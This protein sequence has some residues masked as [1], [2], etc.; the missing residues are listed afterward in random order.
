MKKSAVVASI[1]V[2]LAACG[3]ANAQMC[4]LGKYQ[5][6]PDWRTWDYEVDDHGWANM[7]LV[8]IPWTGD[9]ATMSGTYV[10]EKNPTFQVDPD[11]SGVSNPTTVYGA[12][13]WNHHDTTD[14]GVYGPV[15]FYDAGVATSDQKYL[16]ELDLVKS[17]WECWYDADR[18]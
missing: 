7:L 12:D 13:F 15:E 11:A 6:E 2:M 10:I 1:L 4:Q 14:Q 9:A 8:P 16:L 5:N 18:D 3:A 17:T